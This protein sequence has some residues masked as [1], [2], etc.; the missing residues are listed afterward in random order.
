[1]GRDLVGMATLDDLA[2][3]APSI[4]AFVRDRMAA[5]GLC[6]VGTRR[7]DG[8]PRVSPM[9][10]FECEGRLYVGSMPQA[11]K[12]RDLQRDPRCCVLTPLADKD[13]EAGEAKLFCRAREVTDPDE[14]NAARRAF[15]AE[16][17]MDPLGEPGG[18]PHLFT[19][20][21]EGAAWQRVE[22]EG[23][24]TSSWTVERGREERGRIGADGLSELLPLD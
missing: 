20:D 8:W 4:A 19:F 13:D 16:R 7:A 10:L 14:W 24:R 2:A 17:G 15:E 5:T 18:G 12:A 23:F 11:V 21:I 1:M 6:L 9:E 22:G 3:A